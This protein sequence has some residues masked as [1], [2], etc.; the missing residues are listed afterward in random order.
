L[1]KPQTKELIEIYGELATA[2]E[3]LK[4]PEMAKQAA[5]FKRQL[6]SIP[7]PKGD[8]KK[9]PGMLDPETEET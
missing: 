7:A 5:E 3:K 8:D 1:C 2:Y 6:E 9:K 4:Q